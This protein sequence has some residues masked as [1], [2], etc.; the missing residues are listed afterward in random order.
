M[1]YEKVVEASSTVRPTGS[2]RMGYDLSESKIISITPMHRKTI[3]QYS[4][5]RIKRKQKYYLET[6]CAS[7]CLRGTHRDSEKPPKGD[8]RG[9]EDFSGCAVMTQR[10]TVSSSFSLTVTLRHSFRYL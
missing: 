4:S 10:A 7:E 9:K 8:P 2:V 5:T 1:M 6:Y 3:T